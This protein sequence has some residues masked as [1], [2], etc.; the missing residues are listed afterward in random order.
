MVRRSAQR[1]GN[2]GKNEEKAQG[3]AQIRECPVSLRAIDVHGRLPCRWTGMTT[4][5]ARRGSGEPLVKTGLT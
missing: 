5:A 2:D 4:N 1:E 3:E